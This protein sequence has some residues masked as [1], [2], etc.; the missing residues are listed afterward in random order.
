MPWADARELYALWI[1]S[2]VAAG[3]LD[4]GSGAKYLA[5]VD[6]FVS[7]CLGRRV[8][9]TSVGVVE[10][11]GTPLAQGWVNEVGVDRRTGNPVLPGPAAQRLRRSAG[12]S[13]WAVLRLFGLSVGDLFADVT[14][15]P[16]VDGLAIRPLEDGEALALRTWA[17]RHP[18]QSAQNAAV[19]GALLGAK[20]ATLAQVQVCDVD[21]AQG[22][23]RL[24]ATGKY[25]SRVL[26]LDPF[27]VT[28][29]TRRLEDVYALHTGPADVLS[30]YLISG[31]DKPTTPENTGNLL[32]A[33]LDLAGLR[34]QHL[35]ASSLALW[36]SLRAYHHGPGATVLTCGP[37]STGT[38]DISAA[39]YVRGV[40]TRS[41]NEALGLSSASTAVD[42][43]G[44]VN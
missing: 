1:E 38:R 14:V 8:P 17:L 34:S 42:P 13:L 39:A 10:R 22:I 36:G 41:A 26:V 20:Q 11:L 23:V 3:A 16:L 35:T 6:Q 30:L 9:L 24:P 2:Q 5:T 4:E 31:G 7:Y 15:P 12:R 25:R 29:F 32:R 27:A 37:S 43:Y 33:A 40:T 18:L 21:L 19:A 28:V 44:F